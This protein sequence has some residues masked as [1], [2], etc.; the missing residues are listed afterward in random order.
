MT[1]LTPIAESIKQKNPIVGDVLL[2][3]LEENNLSAFVK[4]WLI[5]LNLITNLK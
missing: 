2:E 5:L 4:I 3:K 1:E